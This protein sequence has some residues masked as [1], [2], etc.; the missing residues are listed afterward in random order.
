MLA[1]FRQLFRL[2]VLAAIFVLAC[3]RCFASSLMGRSD[4]ELLQIMVGGKAESRLRGGAKIHVPERF[5]DM[6]PNDAAR[7]LIRENCPTELRQAFE[8]NF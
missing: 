6:S 3:L 1:T 2:F 7:G 8:F 4:E 5:W